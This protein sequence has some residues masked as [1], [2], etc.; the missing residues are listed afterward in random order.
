[1]DLDNAVHFL[2]QIML[3]FKELSVYGVMHR[4]MKPQNILIKQD[5]TVVIADF[6]FAMFDQSM[7]DT[8]L[9]MYIA[10]LNISIS[11]QF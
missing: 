8:V 3:G 4:D 9:G 10:L 5:Y 1:M 11:L 7:A 6:G 2:K